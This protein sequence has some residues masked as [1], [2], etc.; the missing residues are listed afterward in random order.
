MRW[1]QNVEYLARSCIAL[2]ACPKRGFSGALCSCLPASGLL[3]VTLRPAAVTTSTEG[4]SRRCADL[5]RGDGD[6]AEQNHQSQG[7]VASRRRERAG[8]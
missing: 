2:E 8:K 5:V 3:E 6:D 7:G 4:K 1:N